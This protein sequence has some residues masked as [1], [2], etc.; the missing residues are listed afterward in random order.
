[1]KITIDI[2]NG[3]IH[4][5]HLSIIQTVV[6]PNFETN[7]FMEFCMLQKFPYSIAATSYFVE[8]SKVNIMAMFT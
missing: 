6:E 5:M 3:T 2:D 7:Y 4:L 8:I 1:M